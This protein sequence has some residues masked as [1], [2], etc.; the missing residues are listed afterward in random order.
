[1]VPD[2][3]SRVQTLCRNRIDKA[4]EIDKVIKVT[5]EATFS[6]SAVDTKEILLSIGAFWKDLQWPTAT[7]S[8]SYTA[9]I[10]QHICDCAVY[11]VGK[12]YTLVTDEDIYRGGQFQASEKVP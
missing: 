5:D 8:Y 4:I 10:V 9:A 6:S 11:Y 7:E 2:W 12:V 1:M 3:I